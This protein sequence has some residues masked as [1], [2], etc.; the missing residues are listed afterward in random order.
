MIEKGETPDMSSLT[1]Q[2]RKQMKL[3]LAKYVMNVL[4]EDD[5]ESKQI[6]KDFEKRS[7][8]AE[9][10]DSGMGRCN[11]MTVDQHVDVV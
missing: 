9:S 4:S 1:G 5:E 10:I 11:S 6:R 2:E 8:S 7:N 3:K